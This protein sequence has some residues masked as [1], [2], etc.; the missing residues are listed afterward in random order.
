MFG[1]E[2]LVVVTPVVPPRSLEG[3][4]LRAE[5]LRAFEA[6]AVFHV[7]GLVARPLLTSTGEQA[8][9]RVASD[10]PARAGMERKRHAIE[11]LPAVF[12][13]AQVGPG[14]PAA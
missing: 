12:L 4:P 5:A 13:P 9:F 7:T 10:D 6:Q 8:D 11:F 14:A 1:A 2:A 3:D